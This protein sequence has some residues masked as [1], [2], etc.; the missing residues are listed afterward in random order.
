MEVMLEWGKHDNGDI[1]ESNI[2]KML[3]FEYTCSNIYVI[4][5]WKCNFYMIRSKTRLLVPDFCE[6]FGAE[7][8]LDVDGS[9][10]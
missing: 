4:A 5:R 6:D 7:T 3:T 9:S 10:A 1:W 8:L 2:E